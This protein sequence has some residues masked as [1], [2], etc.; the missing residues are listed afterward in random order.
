[1]VNATQR[2]TRVAVVAERSRSINKT[3]YALAV[4]IPEPK[5]VVVSTL[6]FALMFDLFV[7]DVLVAVMTF[8]LIYTNLHY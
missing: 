8:V 5:P 6:T 2:P 1:M 3:S 7:W 4:V